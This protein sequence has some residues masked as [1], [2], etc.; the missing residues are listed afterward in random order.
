MVEKRSKVIWA[1][2]IGYIHPTLARI[3]GYDPEH[4][5]ISAESADCI[6]G[7]TDIPRKLTEEAIR[8]FGDDIK[9][10]L[11]E[12]RRENLRSILD[13]AYW[14]RAVGD[15]ENEIN[16]EF[17]G[18]L[19]EFRSKSMN[20]AQFDKDVSELAK[21]ISSD[22]KQALTRIVETCDYDDGVS[23]PREKLD[24][25]S[26]SCPMCKSKM[27][28]L[29]TEEYVMGDKVKHYQCGG[30]CGSRFTVVYGKALPSET[31][32]DKVPTEDGEYDEDL[33]DDENVERLIQHFADCLDHQPTYDI[34]T[35]EDFL[36][37]AK[38]QGFVA[39]FVDTFEDDLRKGWKEALEEYMDSKG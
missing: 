38:E 13:R 6:P 5:D 37:G 29:G 32:P 1:T 23:S 15:D 25:H 2:V 30:Q 20:D 11:M 19:C 14:F 9:I 18:E 39:E 22:I 10:S 26:I 16:E 34:I 4:P 31:E 3:L 12:M 8:T 7:A 24:E 35:W 28:R 36:E 33:S 17:I 27:L 21:D